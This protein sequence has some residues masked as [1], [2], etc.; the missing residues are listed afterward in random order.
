M[1]SGKRRK[2]RQMH[3]EFLVLRRHGVKCSSNDYSKSFVWTVHTV[4]V[5]GAFYI[6]FVVSHEAFRRLVLGR[7]LFFAVHV[8]L[9]VLTAPLY[10]L[11]GGALLL[12]LPCYWWSLGHFGFCG[13]SWCVNVCEI[14][15]FKM[16]DSKS[17][18]PNPDWDSKIGFSHTSYLFSHTRLE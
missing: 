7:R 10:Y 1:A 14:Q 17:I 12:L 6:A 11:V 2:G 8:L 16:D 18:E 9:I 13:W 15:F 5:W 3:L 4:G